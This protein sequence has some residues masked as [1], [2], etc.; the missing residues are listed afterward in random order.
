LSGQLQTPGSLCVNRAGP[1]AGH[2]ACSFGPC[3]IASLPTQTEAQQ[4]KPPRGLTRTR[5]RGG[6]ARRARPWPWPLKPHAAPTPVV[7]GSGPSTARDWSLKEVVVLAAAS[8]TVKGGSSRVPP[9]PGPRRK[10]GLHGCR[11]V[12]P[13]TS[14]GRPCF[15]VILSLIVCLLLPANYCISEPAAVAGLASRGRGSKAAAHRRSWAGPSRA[16]IHLYSERV[17]LGYRRVWTVGQC[18][19]CFRVQTEV[20][21]HRDTK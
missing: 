6:R 14:R 8:E 21:V 7:L 12:P 20:R 11:L 16:R 17:S 19:A 15:L 1:A 5:R 3:G 13:R 10:M 18:C 9:P 2:T 4:H